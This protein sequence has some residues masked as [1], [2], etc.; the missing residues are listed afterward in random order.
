MKDN[1]MNDIKY[2]IDILRT[3]AFYGGGDN[4]EI[5]KG[6]YQMI[7]NWTDAKTKIKRIL[8]AKK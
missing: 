5:A 4:I 7:S 3:N 6:K 1:N 8:K 2:A